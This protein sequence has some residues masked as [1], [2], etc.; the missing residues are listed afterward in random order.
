VSLNKIQ[1]SHDPLGKPYFTF[2]PELGSLV[3]NA[4][5]TRHHLSI[6]DE[7]SLVCAFVILEK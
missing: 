7:L 5:I 2:H 3:K 4:G 1:I 6:S